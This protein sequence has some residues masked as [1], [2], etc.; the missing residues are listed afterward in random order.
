MVTWPDVNELILPGNIDAGASAEQ[1]DLRH[2]GADLVAAV[3][4]PTTW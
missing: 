3:R 4:R 2:R 1:A